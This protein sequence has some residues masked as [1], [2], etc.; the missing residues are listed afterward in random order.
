MLRQERD[1]REKYLEGVRQ[2]EAAQQQERQR[3]RADQDEALKRMR[4]PQETYV[5]SLG[6]PALAIA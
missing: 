5:R 1:L 3:Q 2:K 6:F 4:Q